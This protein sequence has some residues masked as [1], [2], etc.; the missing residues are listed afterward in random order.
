MSLRALRFAQH[1]LREAI[2]TLRKPG[3]ASF[4]AFLEMTIPQITT[5][6]P[7]TPQK[8]LNYPIQ[9]STNYGA[10]SAVVN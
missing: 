2:S 10:L 8:A 5:N 6:C 4:L 3:I 7:L 9:L 1:K